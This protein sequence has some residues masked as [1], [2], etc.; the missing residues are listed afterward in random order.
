[1]NDNYWGELRIRALN[2]RQKKQNR[3]FWFD[4]TIPT[5]SLSESLVTRGWWTMF[6][7]ILAVCDFSYL[8]TIML[9]MSFLTIKPYVFM[10]LS[11][12]SRRKCLGWLVMSLP[13]F[14]AVKIGNSLVA[15]HNCKSPMQG[16][17]MHLQKNAM[18]KY[19][20]GIFMTSTPIQIAI[21]HNPT[22]TLRGWFLSCTYRMIQLSHQNRLF[23]LLH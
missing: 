22:I 10:L 13:Y 5:P 12:P 17:Y 6:S 20:H 15:N 4:L 18:K 8:Q 14:I 16:M 7:E 9:E 11:Y 19:G 1:M 23:P 21:K 2:P 3:P